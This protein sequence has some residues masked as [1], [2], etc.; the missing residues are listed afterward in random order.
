MCSSVGKSTLVMK[1]M[2]EWKMT[3]G[4]NCLFR[5]ICESREEK[6]VKEL[7]SELKPILNSGDLKVTYGVPPG[8]P[9]KNQV[10]HMEIRWQNAMDQGCVVKS[11]IH[12][13]S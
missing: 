6:A 2:S 11:F 9:D 8:L 13:R 1:D 4:M 12:L 10:R 5:H 7:V 3:F